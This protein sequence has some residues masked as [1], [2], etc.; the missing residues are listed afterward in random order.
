MKPYKEIRSEVLTKLKE[1]KKEIELKSKERP[2]FL[3][4]KKELEKTVTHWKMFYS[5][6]AMFLQ[7]I[8]EGDIDKSNLENKV[9]DF[10][11]D[12][13]RFRFLSELKRLPE[14]E[15]ENIVDLLTTHVK[16]I[17]IEGYDSFFFQKTFTKK[18][19]LQYLFQ[20]EKEGIIL[21]EQDEE[22]I[23]KII[24]NCWIT[25]L[26]AVIYDKKKNMFPVY[27]SL[28]TWMNY[29]KVKNR[30]RSDLPSVTKEFVIENSMKKQ[31][32]S[33]I[34]SC[35][36]EWAH[37]VSTEEDIKAEIVRL[38]DNDFVD[39][40]HSYSYLSYEEK[41]LKTLC[42][43]KIRLKINVLIGQMEAKIAN[44]Q[45]WNISD[46]DEFI[47]TKLESVKKYKNMIRDIEKTLK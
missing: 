4:I 1:K 7:G 40:V 3:F 41:K 23:Q 34:K 43:E 24:Q 17:K 37:L 9:R 15:K 21:S 8:F 31:E 32:A 30:F 19:R 45:E 5:F 29:K 38:L 6:H 33:L 25:V 46:A 39:H 10:L 12:H 44:I 13:F 18:D 36:R 47:K 14:K 27:E 26:S 16:T 11:K 28:F 42:I 22:D 20:S 2:D 35:Y